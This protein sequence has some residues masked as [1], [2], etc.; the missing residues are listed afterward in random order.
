MNPNTTAVAEAPQMTKSQMIDLLNQDLAKEYSACIQYVQHA[1][2]ITGAQYEGIMKELAIHA[3]EELAH[4]ISLSEQI[5]F[6]GGVPGVDVGNVYLDKAPDKMLR[7]DL[8]GEEDAIARYK[9]R[10]RQAEELSE[11]GLRRVLEDILIIEEEHKRDLLT[12]L[13]Q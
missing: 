7:L 11:F 6:L 3:N 4:A 2:V 13:G 8:D 10:I 12:A 9:V 5:N 1:S